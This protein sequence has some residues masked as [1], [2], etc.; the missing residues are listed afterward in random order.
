[1]ILSNTEIFKAL[2]QGRIIIRP[3]PSPRN[4]KDSPYSTTSIDLCLGSEIA[5]L[6]KD[7]AFT[8]SLESG[9]FNT[10]YTESNSERRNLSPREAFTM[11]PQQFIIAQTLEW[12]ELPIKPGGPWYAARVEGKSSLARCG[13][14]VHFTAP[15]IHAGFAGN[16]TLEMINLNTKPITV[17]QGERICQLIIE[18]VKGK[19][20]LYRHSQFQKQT[21]PGGHSR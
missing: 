20:V 6:K 12:I 1:M 10:I 17:K 13:V 11:E 15:T 18:E 8:L 19:P 2:D 7:L 3:G 5:W 4:G 9:K 14:L 21:R 16:L